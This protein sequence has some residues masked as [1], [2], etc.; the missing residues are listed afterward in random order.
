VDNYKPFFK[1]DVLVIMKKYGICLMTCLL[2]ASATAFGAKNLVHRGMRDG[3]ITRN[4]S[5]GGN[6]Y[7]QLSEYITDISLGGA[8]STIQPVTAAAGYSHSAVIQIDSNGQYSLYT[9]GLNNYGQLGLGNA[10]DRTEYAK[11]AGFAAGEHP[12]AVS[13]GYYHTMVITQDNSGNRYLYG[14]GYNG[15]GELGL[16]NTANRSVFAK[17]T[18][19][20]GA[21]EQP[22]VVSAGHF[23]TMVI[24]QNKA[25]VLRLYGTGH[26]GAGQLGLGDTTNRLV[27]TPVTPNLVTGDVFVNVAC[28]GAHSMIITQNMSTAARSLYATGDN[29]HGQ[30]GRGAVDVGL[31]E[32]GI[33][34]PATFVYDAESDLVE[35]IT[36]EPWSVS[37]GAQH[38]LLVVKSTDATATQLN[39]FATGYNT[40]GQ[41]GIASNIDTSVFT[42]EST[43]LVKD[44]KEVYAGYYHSMYLT[45]AGGLWGAGLNKNDQIGNNTI[46]STDSN[47]FVSS[48]NIAD[49]Q[50]ALA[51]VFAVAAGG[52]HTLA[53]IEKTATSNTLWVAGLNAYGQLGTGDKVSTSDLPI[54]GFRQ[55]SGS[56]GFGFN[57]DVVAEGYYH[58][59]MIVTNDTP[60]ENL[61]YGTGYNGYG[62]LGLAVATPSYSN[63]TKVTLPTGVTTPTAVSCGYYHTLLIAANSGDKL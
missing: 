20:F 11:V 14:T 21:G 27:F 54:K 47:I 22:L 56:I 6:G 45:T 10:I 43:G 1:G 5:V 61:L 49:P 16:G 62:Q 50:V 46:P 57:P 63:L 36:R 34:S 12:V 13:A 58:S 59:M 28:G 25:G 31:T 19:G 48:G 51:D 42:Q 40:Y 15:S 18:A 3:M 35:P 24:T 33:V 55:P 29:S 41:L 37:A 30:L 8:G 60:A 44:A 52:A 32:F 23:H 2:M 17:V 39:V 4:Y 38:T 7:G 53:L 26:N 9:T